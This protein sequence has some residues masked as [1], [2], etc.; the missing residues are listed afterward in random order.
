LLYSG[1]VAY[2]FGSPPPSREGRRVIDGECPKSSKGQTPG[3]PCPRQL[4]HLRW[5]ISRLADGT[6]LDPFAGSG[7]ALLAAHEAGWPAVGIE[8]EEKYCELAAK[9][10][11]NAPG[12]LFAFA[13]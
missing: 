2:A 13:S 12:P 9:R 1:D 3:H 6:V 5:I 4:N 10:L 8:V 7:T 11:D